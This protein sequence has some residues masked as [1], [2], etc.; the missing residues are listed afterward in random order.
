MNE[1][2]PGLAHRIAEEER[3][4]AYQKIAHYHA[5]K[6]AL[7]QLP[8]EH[9]LDGVGVENGGVDE[10]ER[11]EHELH[12]RGHRAHGE[13]P[14]FQLGDGVGEVSRRESEEAHRRHET[15]AHGPDIFVHVRGQG[16][17]EEQLQRLVNDVEAS[18]QQGGADQ[19]EQGAEPKP[20]IEQP[21]SGVALF[22]AKV[23]GKADEKDER[24]EEKRR[25]E[26]DIPLQP[27]Q[28]C[29][30][31]DPEHPQQ[32]AREES[33]PLG[34]DVEIDRHYPE[35]R[36]SESPHDSL[37]EIPVVVK[38]LVER[39]QCGDGDRERKARDGDAE[40]GKP[41]SPPGPECS[42]AHLEPPLPSL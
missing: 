9:D 25:T 12:E 28:T 6:R 14:L 38:E 19:S 17:A 39:E 26:P 16:N 34:F 15:E 2:A 13:V 27:E 18:S 4:G 35:K 36:G 42:L 31:D 37:L 7:G 5:A 20:V 22:A 10:E 8:G 24:S 1:R 41:A 40:I 32:D 11:T 23:P 29:N 21:E 33:A 3:R 30:H